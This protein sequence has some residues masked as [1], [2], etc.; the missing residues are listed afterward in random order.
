MA[1]GLRVGICVLV[2]AVLFEAHEDRL[3]AVTHASWRLLVLLALCLAGCVVDHNLGTGQAAQTQA[4][5]TS[6]WGQV[7]GIDLTTYTLSS[8]QGRLVPHGIIPNGTVVTVYGASQP[9]GAFVRIEPLSHL[10]HLLAQS[11]FINP[12]Q[13]GSWNNTRS[14]PGSWQEL[15]LLSCPM[16]AFV[17]DGRAVYAAHTQA[18]EM[19]WA[20]TLDDNYLQ[21]TTTSG[22]PAI[23][24]RHC[25]KRYPADV[26]LLEEYIKGHPNAAIDASYILGAQ[27]ASSAAKQLLWNAPAVIDGAQFLRALKQMHFNLV[28]NT[29]QVYQALRGLVGGFPLVIEFLNAQNIPAAVSSQS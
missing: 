15:P 18:D 2:H 16:H 8:K 20:V 24:S 14:T 4:A 10:G 29:A 19:L 27:R 7:A 17:E 12:A 9:S 5:I 13:V 23:I 3:A 21:T 11:L 1:A 6:W 28:G 26:E 22:A 25:A